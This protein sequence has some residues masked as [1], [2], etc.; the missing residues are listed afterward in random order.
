MTGCKEINDTRRDNAKNEK[1]NNSTHTTNPD[2]FLTHSYFAVRQPDNQ[3]SARIFYPACP[4]CVVSGNL[5]SKVPQI[6]FRVFPE[7]SSFNIPV[8][9][10]CLFPV[11]YSH[12][13]AFRNDIP[14]MELNC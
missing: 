7:T 9:H 13:L 1:G 8:Q 10:V 14:I 11:H 4:V 5:Q 2:M 6:Y 12:D 3:G